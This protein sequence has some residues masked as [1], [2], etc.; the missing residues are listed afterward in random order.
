MTLDAPF[1]VGGRIHSTVWI[2]GSE[3]KMDSS[4]ERRREHK[5]N[6]RDVVKFD[7]K[8]QTLN[9]S[10]GKRQPSPTQ[11]IFTSWYLLTVPKWNDLV[12]KLKRCHSDGGR[13]ALYDGKVQF[14]ILCCL[15]SNLI[16]LLIKNIHTALHKS[17][18]LQPVLP[19]YA[20]NWVRQPARDD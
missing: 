11:K 10:L 2:V 18:K 14:G 9:R 4:C 6:M 17:P 1:G 5:E 15:L 19:L 13:Q 12:L 16:D 8:L 20:V 7:E 3:D